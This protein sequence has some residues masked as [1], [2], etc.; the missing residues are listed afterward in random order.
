MY[1]MKQNEQKALQ[2]LSIIVQTLNVQTT[3]DK[4]DFNIAKTSARQARY[5]VNLI[6]DRWE[7]ERIYA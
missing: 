6:I 1:I 7:E 2:E 5:L 4:K 3:F